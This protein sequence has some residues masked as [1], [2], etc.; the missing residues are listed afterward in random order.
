MLARA[1]FLSG[2]LFVV[3]GRAV[4]PL[5]LAGAVLLPYHKDAHWRRALVTDLLVAIVT[6]AFVRLAA[7]TL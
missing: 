2:L 3:I 1:S 5:L 7:G 4:P 6:A